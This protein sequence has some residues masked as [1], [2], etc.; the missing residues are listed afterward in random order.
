MSNHQQVTI[1][2]DTNNSPEDPMAKAMAQEQQPPITAAM[3]PTEEPSV[4]SERPTWL[5]EKFQNPED[6]AKAYSELEKK[7]S[8][9]KPAKF[10]GLEKYTEEF[11][12]SGDLSDDSI[13][14]IAAMGIPEQIVR[15]YVD[16]QKSVV[17]SNVNAVFGLA[18][19][20]EK[21]QQLVSWAGE[22]IPE[23][24]VDAFNSV[25]ESGN[26]NTIRL[27]VQGLR[28]RYD[29]ANGQSGRLIQGETT[30]PSGNAFR[31]IAEIVEA[32]KDPRY[33]KDAAYRADVEKR[34]ALSNALGVS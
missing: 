7:F 31:S 27:A 19:G 18:G 11:N 13:K 32:M 28:A 15:A 1:V 2:R 3:Q 22:N 26:M 10:E 9:D 33:S 23:D 25:I 5:P 8:G 21:Y 12:K 4:A 34:V 14:A 20:Q 16:G 17:E 24:E 6:L 29:Q 30:G